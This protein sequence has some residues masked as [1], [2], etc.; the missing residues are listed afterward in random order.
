MSLSQLGAVFAHGV[1]EMTQVAYLPDIFIKMKQI[2]KFDLFDVR[3]KTM[4]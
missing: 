3:L 2:S 1:Q 4:L